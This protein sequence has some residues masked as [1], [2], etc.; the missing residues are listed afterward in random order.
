MSMMDEIYVEFEKEFTN[1]IAGWLQN[2]S[3]LVGTVVGVCVVMLIIA[4]L[5]SWNPAAADAANPNLPT[6]L[7]SGLAL[8]S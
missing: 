4:A 1:T 5:Q 7:H 6:L 2:G 3:L 8:A